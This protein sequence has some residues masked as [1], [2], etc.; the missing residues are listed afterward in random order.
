MNSRGIGCFKSFQEFSDYFEE[1]L[2]KAFRYFSFRE[3][4]WWFHGALEGFR[5]L[6][7]ALRKASQVVQ[8]AMELSCFRRVSGG[9]S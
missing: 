2:R 9:N 3:V 8:G 1:S 5:G 4:S 6:E 7:K